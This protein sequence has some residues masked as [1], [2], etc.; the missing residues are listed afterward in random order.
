MPLLE[1]RDLTKRFDGLVA[2]DGVSFCIAEGEIVG[3]LGPNGSGKTTLI[4]VIAGRWPPTTGR[5]LFD[6]R[7]ITGQPAHAVCRLGIA[8]TFQTVK[9]FDHLSVLDNVALGVLYGRRRR[10]PLEVAREEARR[11]LETVGLEDRADDLAGTLSMG[12]RKRLELARAL[13]T[14]PRLLLLDEVGAGLTPAGGAALRQLLARLRDEGLTILGVEH[15]LYA[16]ADIADRLIV[17]HGGR[18]IAEGLPQEVLG[19]RDVVEAY[20]GE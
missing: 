19:R 9:P 17:L 20:M 14:Q 5:V 18:I 15:T 8:R 10:G 12:Q 1:V 4:N 7:D 2:L 16:M 3:L 6:G 13:A 11:F